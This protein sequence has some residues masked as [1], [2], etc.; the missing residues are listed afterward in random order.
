MSVSEGADYELVSAS[1]DEVGARA[2]VGLVRVVGVAE[3]SYASV[4][5]GALLEAVCIHSCA[6]TDVIENDECSTD[7]VVDVTP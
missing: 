2:S 1:S 3:S 6:L 7:E 5:T 4:V